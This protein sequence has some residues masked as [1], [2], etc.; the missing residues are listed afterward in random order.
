M[1]TFRFL[2]TGLLQKIGLVGMCVAM[3]LVDAHAQE[4]RCNVSVVAPSIQG[5]NRKV[6]ETLQTALN[7]FMN[8]QRWTDKVYASEERI[9]CNFMLNIK[10]MISIDEFKGTLQ[11]QARRPVYNSSYNTVL[12]NYQDQNLHFKYV[13]FEPLVFNPSNFDSNLIGMMAFYAYMIIG[14]DEDSFA[15]MGGT[16]SFQK[17]EQIVNRAQNASQTGWKSFEN[18]RNRYW[19]VEN[20]LDEY[21]KPLRECVY[22]YHRLGLD[23]LAEKVETGREESAN[24][25]ELLR[26]VYRQK[27]GAFLLQIFFNAKADEVVNLFSE[28]FGVEKSNM[29]NLLTEIDPSNLDKYKALK[30]N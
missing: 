3:A 21:H 14:L 4:L 28:S 30:S 9:E 12:F 24:A 26:K 29:Y 1:A 23:R 18:Q 20:M 8:N 13:E 22:R 11:I 5:T 27:P 2:C 19:M 25:L 7:E 6:F 17:A 10:E 16:S 15:P